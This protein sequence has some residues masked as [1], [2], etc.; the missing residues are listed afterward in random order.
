MNATKTARIE[1]KSFF[2]GELTR[3]AELCRADVDTGRGKTHTHNCALVVYLQFQLLDFLLRLGY[4][5]SNTKRYRDQLPL[6]FHLCG[7]IHSAV[8]SDVKAAWT[9]ALRRAL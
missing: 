8:S 5:F 3:S 4:L 9:A 2:N 1:Q 6:T 7:P